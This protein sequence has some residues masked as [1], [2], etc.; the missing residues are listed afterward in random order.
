MGVSIKPE[1]NLPQD[2]ERSMRIYQVIGDEAQ[3]LQQMGT[4]ARLSEAAE[5]SV[6]IF[7]SIADDHYRDRLRE[8]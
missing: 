2:P 1:E 4:L 3:R 8:R 5:Y 6:K 7:K